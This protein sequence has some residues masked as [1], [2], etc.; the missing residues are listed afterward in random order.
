MAEPDREAFEAAERLVREAHA[1][2][3]EAARDAAARRAAERLGERRG[4]AAA[5]RSRT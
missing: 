4:A 2:A 1:A 5:P 3:E